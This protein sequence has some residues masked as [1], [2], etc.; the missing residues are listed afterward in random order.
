M[1][2]NLDDDFD[3]DN[4]DL[5]LRPWGE[6]RV[7]LVLAGLVQA[8]SLAFLWGHIAVVWYIARTVSF[9]AEIRDS[10]QF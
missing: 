7:R 2:M 1:S 8:L 3:W 5:Q 10:G 9:I 6:S 4:Q